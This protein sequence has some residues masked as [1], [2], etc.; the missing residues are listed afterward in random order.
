MRERNWSRAGS[1]A[2]KY[3]GVSFA[4]IAGVTRL[5]ST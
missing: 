3:Y 2:E 5:L 1:N 4:L